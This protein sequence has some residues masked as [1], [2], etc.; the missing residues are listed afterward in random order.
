MKTH[1]TL[2]LALATVLVSFPAHAATSKDEACR[3]IEKML[4]AVQLEAPSMSDRQFD[5][6]N[7]SLKEAF[8]RNCE[9]ASTGVLQDAMSSTAAA[10]TYANGA[11]LER[12][13]HWFLPDGREFVE[14]SGILAD[15]RADQNS[16][17]P[18]FAPFL[19]QHNRCAPGC[20]YV[21]WG[22]WGDAR[23]QAKRSCHNSGEAIDIHAITCGGKTYA[24]LSARFTEY[25]S[26]MKGTLQAIYG[27]GEH[28]DHAHLQLPGCAFCQ[29]LHCSGGRGQG[30][31]S[32]ARGPVQHRS[33]QKAPVRKHKRRH[34]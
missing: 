21:S 16:N 18:I 10:P 7:E 15:A 26:C 30:D 28:A 22:I 25:V 14:E 6:A 32:G 13:G 4:V 20:G 9:A 2:S 8:T 19:A 34:A 17:A 11:A 24:A 29:G 23:H 5:E 1:H 3:K 12:D 27:S 33:A 31:V